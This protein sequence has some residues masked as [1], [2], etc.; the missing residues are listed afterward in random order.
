MQKNVRIVNSP[1]S[2]AI[3]VVGD[4]VMSIQVP[5]SKDDV[6]MVF[7]PALVG[8]TE[9]A[10]RPGVQLRQMKVLQNTADTVTARFD[11]RAH[12]ERIITVSGVPY[13]VKLLRI[14][15]ELYDG[16]KFPAFEFLVTW[17]APEGSGV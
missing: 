17:D 7:N 1:I 14:D 10:D 9:N 11:F 6:T 16:Q 8:Y 12:N 2:S 3:E 5:Y 13:T 4:M 15:S